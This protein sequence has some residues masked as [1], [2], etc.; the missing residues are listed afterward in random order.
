M[1]AYSIDSTNN[2]LTATTNWP[3]VASASG[4]PWKYVEVLNL[5]GASTVTYKIGTSNPTD[6]TSLAADTW[7]LPAAAGAA[8][9]HELDASQSALY[10]DVIS[11]GTPKVVVTAW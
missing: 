4:G 5:D 6:P 8:R 11:A 7:I 10:V 2:T 9:A 1:S 3:A